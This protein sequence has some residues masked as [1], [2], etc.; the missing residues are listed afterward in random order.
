[1]RQDL[2]RQMDDYADLLVR[3]GVALQPGQELVVDAPVEA[4]A[5]VRRVVRA[6]YA[7]GAGHVT[8]NWSDDALRRLEY[9]NV[10]LEWFEETPSWKREQMNSLAAQGAC[11]L[12]L[13]GSDPAALDGI[14][15][16]KPVAAATARNSQCS[17]WRHG[18]DFGENAWCIAGVPVA[19]WSHAVFPDAEDD[20]QANERMWEAIFSTARA[21]G[22][23]PVAA[24]REHD[25]ELAK[26]RAAM[27]GLGLDGLRYRSSN[28][29]DLVV[30]L[31]A[32]H[33]WGGGSMRLADGRE[34]QPNI[35]TEEV[36]TSPDRLRA[37]GMVRSTMPLVYQGTTIQGMWLRFEAGRVVEFGA[38]EGRAS[39]ERLLAV[40]E[41]ARRLGEVA[42]IAKDTPIRR[43]G[44]LFYNTLFDENASCHLALGKGF[45]ECQRDGSSL[46]EDELLAR[47]VNR[48]HAHVDFMV[49]ADD[50]SITG[51]AASGEEVPVFEDGLW[52]L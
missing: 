33:V 2:D 6:A 35:P 50:L 11:F 20:E 22:G 10:A 51:L 12:S 41:G 48:S 32:G 38:D 8:T 9:E 45:A 26:R 1:M 17:V 31:P 4:A 21:D 19:A 34:F 40:D 24:W 18:L 46:D 15:P 37:E 27:N 49:G 14:D 39:L 47:G 44:L 28:G 3:V 36:F 16:A 52:A 30:G 29:T 42:L 13:T 23:D 43:S 25:A 5:F 7:A